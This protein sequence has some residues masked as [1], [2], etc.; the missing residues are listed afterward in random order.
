MSIDLTI[1]AIVFTLILLLVFF[2][3]VVLYLSFR[4]KETFRK[5]SKKGT[6]IIK[7]AFLIGILFLAGA[8]FYFSAATLTNT[9]QP[10]PTASPTPTTNPTKPGNTPTPTPTVS[11]SPIFFYTNIHRILSHYNYHGLANNNHLHNH[12]S[13]VH[14]LQKRNNP[15]KHT[16]PIFHRYLRNPRRKRQ[17]N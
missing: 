2:S 9:N 10:T 11:A 1:I 16:I 17:H 12:K 7:T 3:A 15:N 8:I 14:C 5:E 4:I 6:N 13:Y